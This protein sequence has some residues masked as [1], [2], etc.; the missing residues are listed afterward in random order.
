LRLDCAIAI[1]IFVKNV[2][3]GGETTNAM[4]T[5]NNPIRIE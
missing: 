5:P 1:W 2:N 4:L 3:P